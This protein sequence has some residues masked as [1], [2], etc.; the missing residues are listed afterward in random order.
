MLSQTALGN[1]S[2]KK[3]PWNLPLFLLMIPSLL[4]IIPLFGGGLVYGFFQSM[5]YFPGAGGYEISFQHYHQVLFSPDFLQSFWLTFY[6]AGTS[7]LLAA[8]IS[9]I[10]SVLLMD[11]SSKSGWFYFVLQIPLTVPHLVIAVAAIFLLDPAGILSRLLYAGG[12]IQDSGS[13]PLLIHD[14]AGVGIIFS[15]VWKEIPFITLMLTAALKQFGSEYN[16]VGKTLNAGLFSRLR[17]IF[18]PAVMPNLASAALIVFAFTFGAFEVPWLLGKTW[19]RMLPVQAYQ[20][21]S[22]VDLLTRPEGI[23]TG[24]IIALIVGITYAASQL[25]GRLNR[26]RQKAV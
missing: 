13:F 25:L 22:D 5:G 12:M 24:L 7:T 6:V 8:L 11:Y 26:F 1:S 23:A 10:L 17:Y 9:L 18:L 20:Q 19:P 14:D 15:Y 2:L 4:V 21:F 16:E 3:I